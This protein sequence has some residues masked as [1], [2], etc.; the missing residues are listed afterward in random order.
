[1]A[2]NAR[3]CSLWSWASS[4]RP[5]ANTVTFRHCF[6]ETELVFTTPSPSA[7]PSTPGGTLTIQMTASVH[8]Q[9]FTDLIIF[10][11]TSI[12]LVESKCVFWLYILESRY[13]GKKEEIKK[14]N[15]ATPC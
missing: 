11:L 5:A 8:D 12:G 14:R 3:S 4:L 13:K 9:R 15:K 1:M 10:A 7:V 2:G 6:L